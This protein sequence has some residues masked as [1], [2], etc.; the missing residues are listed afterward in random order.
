M[1]LHALGIVHAGCVYRAVEDVLG[2]VDVRIVLIAAVDALEDR[3]AFT[4]LQCDMAATV[5]GLGRVRRVDQ[6]EPGPGETGLVF[7]F[8]LDVRPTVA[9]DTAVQSRFGRRTVMQVASL[10]VG[11]LFRFRLAGHLPGVQRFQGDE[12]VVFDQSGRG[13]RDPIVLAVVDAAAY[14]TH[15]LQCEFASF[16][17]E[18]RGFPITSA[19]GHVLSGELALQTQ[20]L[21]PLPF[22]RLRH[23]QHGPIRQGQCVDAATVDTGL[24]A[25]G[26]PS[27]G[28]RFVGERQSAFRPIHRHA[29]VIPDGLA[30]A[31]V[32][33]ERPTASRF[34]RLA[35][36]LFT[37]P[38]I[39]TTPR[40]RDT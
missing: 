38:V 6:Y 35:E 40:L 25:G 31:H 22:G 37:L 23:V 5:A 20:I 2:R 13:L 10:M 19:V 4:V 29:R 14:R 16:R 12:V 11:V 8:V 15:A 30:D 7:E 24:L 39:T 27:D 32:D 26:I 1:S 33:G 3:L 28:R 21:S 34:A 36:F 17:L 18:F 9:E